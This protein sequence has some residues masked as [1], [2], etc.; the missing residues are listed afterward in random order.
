MSRRKSPRDEIPVPTQ[1]PPVKELED[2]DRQKAKQRPR[3]WLWTL[4]AALAVVLMVVYVV[5]LG[6]LGIY[7]GLKDRARQSQQSAKEHYELGLAYL[8]AQDYELAIGEFEEALRQDSSL[9]EAERWLQEAKELVRRQVTPTSE[10]RQDAVRLLYTQAIDFY[11]KGDLE[12]ALGVLD[13]LYG[14]D[15]E[16]QRENVETM[17]TT[18]HYQLG[19]N[20]VRADQL[21]D[22][23]SHFE[24]LLVF[25]P[26]N[27]D[28]QDQLNLLN[29]YMAALNNW[30]Q[31]WPATIQALKG[32]YTLA[33]EY[34]DVRFRLRDAYLYAAQDHADQGDW[35]RASDQY[36]A[37]VEILPVESTVDRR[38]DAAIRCQATAEAPTVTPT[39]RAAARATATPT[40][41][42]ASAT[43]EATATT[44]P[45]APGNG[46]IAFASFD[47]VRGRTDIYVVDLSQG[48][49][50]LL[51]E[52]ASQPAFAPDRKR[53]AFRNLDPEHLGL[54]VLDL[55]RNELRELTDHVEDSMP[56]WSPD[57]LQ[58][59][60]ASNKHGDRKWRIYA[61]SPGAVRGEGDEWIY[62][63]MPV[64]SPDGSQIAYHGCDER[65]D[66]CGVW[67][68]LAGGFEPKRLTSDASDTAPVWSPDGSEIVYISARAGN[69][70]LYMVDVESGKETRLTEH[71]ATDV[72]PTWSP[73]GNKVAFLSNREG[74][75]AVYI[76]DVR[77]DRVQKVIAT[78]DG[79]PD[80]V[81]EQLSWI[82]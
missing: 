76:L 58:L 74:G 77:S 23:A 64:W 67:L 59:M 50:R 71:S 73:N 42:A 32:L 35:C 18:A 16:Y 29:L 47:A 48:D 6:A 34:K 66:N 5:I 54:G 17:L 3:I 21:E 65:G 25:D 9:Q 79:Y 27:K 52:N 57:T 36:A 8:E 81:S 19:Q 51:W 33:P 49:A 28:A 15:T 44:A 72:A 53:L 1:L 63:H 46:Q 39:G 37:A 13:E 40:A 20:A 61:I 7:D 12:Q 2:Q 43:I 24:A 75:W 70:E 26:E 11:E 38:D 60:F 22:A 4:V 31:D 41:P 14:L 45:R 80:P 78:G 68:A 56:A 82:P 55:D 62:G 30:E 69:W 10:T